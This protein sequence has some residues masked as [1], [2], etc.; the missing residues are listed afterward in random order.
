[1]DLRA[2]FLRELFF[3]VLA[4]PAVRLLAV[5]FL[6]IRPFLAALRLGAF[7]LAVALRDLAFFFPPDGLGG[8]GAA[9]GGLGVK[10]GG[11]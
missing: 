1:M 2:P 9:G 6:A 8:A 4:R 11:V 7:F 3:R 5:R 10:A